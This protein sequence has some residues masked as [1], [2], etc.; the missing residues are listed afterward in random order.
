MYEYRIADI[1]AKETHF[2]RDFSSCNRNFVITKDPQKKLWCWECEKCCFVFLIL[3]AHLKEDELVRIFWENLFD[4]VELEKTFRELIG[5]ENHKPFECVWTYEECL[6]SVKKSL[7][8]FG[9]ALPQVL[10]NIQ[11]E[12]EE[13]CDSETEKKLEKKLLTLS[14]EDI[15]PTDFKQLL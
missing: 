13:R 11:K 5:L 9:D 3:S 14:N 1:F 7:K 4:K 12:I 8:N 2:H 10:I 15:I 6:L